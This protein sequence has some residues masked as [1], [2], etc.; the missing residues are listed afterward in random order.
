MK[1]RGFLVLSLALGLTLACGGGGG[2]G[3]S[4][5]D[6][7]PTPTPSPTPAPQPSVVFT[8]Q[9]GGSPGISL[10]AGAASTASTLVLEVRASSVTDLYGVAFDLIYPNQLLQ[11]VS[12]QQGPFLQGATA[13]NAVLPDRLVI[14]LSR[15]GAVPGENGSGVL[16]TITFRAVGAGQGSFTFSK[17]LAANSQGQAI[18]GVTWSAGTVRVTL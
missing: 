15:L 4:P 17:N 18:P 13:Q 16:M 7:G 8:P 14:G 3:G 5:T 11:F 10:T 6:P 12:L 1:R 9:A 2:G